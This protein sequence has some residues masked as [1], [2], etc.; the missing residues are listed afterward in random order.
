MPHKKKS[1]YYLYELSNFEVADDN[2]DVRGWDVLDADDRTIGKVDHLLV[3]KQTRSVVY[4]DVKVN[5]ELI[6]EGFDAYQVPV[7]EGVHEF[8]NVDGDIHLIIP[9]EMATLDEE[10]KKV[11]TGQI[12][13][14]S[15]TKNN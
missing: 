9:I 7:S 15:F 14:R 12:N 3:N 2:S 11:T 5:E 8:L 6:E 10:N 1:L 4:L 13:S